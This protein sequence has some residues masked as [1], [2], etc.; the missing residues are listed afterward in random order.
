MIDAMRR[1][2]LGLAAL[3]MLLIGASRADDEGYTDVPL[4]Q[5]KASVRARKAIL[6]DVR[7]RKEWDRGHIEGAVLVPLSK[8]AKWERSGIPDAEK[9][10]LKKALPGGSVVYCHCAF[11]SR[12]LPGAEVLRKLGYEARPLRQGYSALIGAGFPK[13]ETSKPAK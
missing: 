7:E 8:L 12:A 2:S 10:A 3:P 5:I 13:A 1:I 11:G 6:V 9:E 4:D